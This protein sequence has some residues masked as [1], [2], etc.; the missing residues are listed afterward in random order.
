[1]PLDVG[2][3]EL[4]LDVM[5]KTRIASSVSAEDAGDANA[6]NS[7]KFLDVSNSRRHALLIA[8]ATWDMTRLATC[9]CKNFLLLLV[10]K[11]HMVL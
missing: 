4:Q 3:H 11:L 5:P 10:S 8:S 2:E 6:V 9:R 1:M 7:V